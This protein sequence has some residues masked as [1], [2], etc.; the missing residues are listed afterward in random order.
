M[1]KFERVNRNII[2]QSQ[3]SLKKTFLCPKAI[4]DLQLFKQK[5]NSFNKQNKSLLFYSVHIFK[6]RKGKKKLMFSKLL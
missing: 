5:A 4:H 6:K 1:T 2:P 3:K